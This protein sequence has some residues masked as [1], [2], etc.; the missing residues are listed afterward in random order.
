MVNITFEKLQEDLKTQNCLLLNSKMEFEIICKT[1]KNI[2]VDIKASCGH[3]HHLYVYHFLSNRPLPQC[4]LCRVSNVSNKMKH[5]YNNNK[6]KMNEIESIGF[7]KIVKYL[8]PY[9]EIQRTNEGCLADFIIRPIGECEDKWIGIQ[10]KTTVKY[11]ETYKQYSFKNFSNY[12]NLLIMC[13]SLEDNK[14]W[15]IPYNLI[16]NVK[17]GISI[18]NTKSKYNKYL[19][20]ETSNIKDV[21]NDN[22]LH[23]EYLTS[24]EFMTPQSKS[25]QQEHKYSLIR[26]KYLNFIKFTKPII[27]GTVTDFLINNFKIQEKVSHQH[28]N[29][30]CVC[31]YVNNGSDEYKKRKYRGYQLGE[32]DFYW[33]HIRSTLAFYMVPQ[34][35]LYKY[36][37]IYGENIIGKRIIFNLSLHKLWLEPYLFSYENLDTNRFYKLLNSV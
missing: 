11:D 21:I 20:K 37:L 26:E 14:L 3:Q 7:N 16:S 23:F 27:Q 12:K 31:L 28:G 32:N 15:I 24:M 5:Q 19:F 34:T 1:D 17:T 6:N 18:S 33:F 2:K 8:T 10:L 29:S 25:Q 36:G 4:K 22:K 30:E 9:F 13:I 35:I